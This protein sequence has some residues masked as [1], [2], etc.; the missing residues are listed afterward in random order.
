MP[1]DRRS[2]RIALTDEGRGLVDR[3]VEGHVQKQLKILAGLAPADREDLTR[4]L[5][6]PL[7]SLA[8][9]R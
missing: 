8:D 5:R 1:G 7:V 2:L 9:T 6:T 4:V 3:T